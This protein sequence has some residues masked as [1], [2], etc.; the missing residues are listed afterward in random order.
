MAILDVLL[1]LGPIFGISTII[2]E[3]R[4]RKIEEWLLRVGAATWKA[5]KV[6]ALI[7]LTFTSLIVMFLSLSLFLRALGEAG[8]L[9]SLVF[10]VPLLRLQYLP[11]QRVGRKFCR[12]WRED[13]PHRL[14]PW[15]FNWFE[16]DFRSRDAFLLFIIWPIVLLGYLVVLLFLIGMAL[17]LSPL[18]LAEWIRLKLT[19][20][21]PNYL[22]TF[23]YCISFVAMIVKMIIGK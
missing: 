20:E 13:F 4:A 11:T 22:N 21:R 16:Q 23:T 2:G 17:A 14:P 19:P 6:L 7:T 10:I 5:S 9:L 18:R 12:W 15:P 8:T 1:T 3:K